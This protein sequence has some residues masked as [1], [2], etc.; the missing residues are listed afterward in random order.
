MKIFEEEKEIIKDFGLDLRRSFKVD[1]CDMYF[2]YI[3]VIS[4]FLKKLNIGESVKLSKI[5]I[6]KVFPFIYRMTNNGL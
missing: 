6:T 1:F 5:T 4:K 3:P 2:E